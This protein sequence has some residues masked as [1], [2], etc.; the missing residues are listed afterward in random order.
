[1]D[2]LFSADSTPTVFVSHAAKD[3]RF[4]KLLA[5][6]L[7]FHDIHPSSDA[8]GLSGASHSPPPRAKTRYVNR[9]RSS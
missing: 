2:P 3:G 6:V 4:V 9:M 8:A 7:Q 1:M 5:A